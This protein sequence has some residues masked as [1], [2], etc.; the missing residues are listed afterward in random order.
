MIDFKERIKVSVKEKK[1]TKREAKETYEKF[2]DIQQKQFIIFI[3][4]LNR[5]I[6]ELREQGIISPFLKFYARIKTTNSALEN[7][8]RKALDDVFGIEFIC[9]TEREIEVLQQMLEKIIKVHKIKLHDKENGYK[10]VH[11]SCSIK[12]ETIEQL[13]KGIWKREYSGFPVV[14]M[15]YKTIQ[16]YWEAVSGRASHEK[17]KD[18]KIPQL[19]ELYDKGK[20]KEGEDIP[21]MWISNADKDNV[22]SLSTKEILRKM[23]PSLQLEKKVSE[24]EK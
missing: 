7:C 3:N 24:K 6:N 11:H 18:T 21:H 5:Y 9:S 20:L 22:R 16:V 2:I 10:A 15:Q 12:D 19:Q 14:E 1:L 23:Y 8:E 4:Y 17:Y 13:E